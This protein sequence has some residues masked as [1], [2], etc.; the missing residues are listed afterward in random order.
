MIDIKI[1]IATNIDFYEKTLPI[2]LGSMKDAE[3]PNEMIYVF[4][5][6]YREEKT[7]VIDGITYIQMA[8]NSYEYSPLIEIT[9]KEMK[10]DYWFLIHDTCKVGPRFKELLYTNIPA[11][12]PAKVALTYKPAMSM[13]LYRYDYLMVL[14]DKIQQIKNTDYS[15][16]RMQWWKAWGVPNED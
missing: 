3:I 9:E 16:E 2:I 5:G 13:G 15:E 11:D 1:A 7:E 6:G 12:M 8:H 4:N 14:K 10:A